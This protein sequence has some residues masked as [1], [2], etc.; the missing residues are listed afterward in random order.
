MFGYVS[1]NKPELKIK[2]FD[3]Y[4]AYYC[5][6]CKKI[7]SKNGNLCRLTLSYDMNFLQILLSSLYDVDTTTNRRRCIAHPFH[8]HMFKT[9]CITEY[10][11]D[12][13]VLL[14]YEKLLD[15]WMDEKK[16]FRKIFSILIYGKS[17]KIQKFYLNKSKVIQYHLQKL[18]DFE[19]SQEETNLDEISGCFGKIV[20][21]IYV[22]KNDE[23]EQDLRKLGFFMGKFIYIMD[24]YD[25]IEKDIKNNSY[26][27]L[28]K[29]YKE[30]NFDEECHRIL[31]LMASEC[32]RAFERLPIVENTGVLR[33]ILYSG[34][35]N[36]YFVINKERQENV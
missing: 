19:K 3:D 2:E 28:R 21:E 23:W 5:G 13:N 24:A 36:R 7:G 12:M 14:A 30:Q 8:K 9:N 20:E 25:D 17:K 32:A 11:A 22:Y 1:I 15:D 29:L 18:H 34:I 35:W 4:R 10:V 6:L 26:N 16:V 31:E 27:P 33:N